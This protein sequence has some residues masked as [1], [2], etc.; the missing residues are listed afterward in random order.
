MIISFFLRNRGCRHRCIFCSE[1]VTGGEGAEDL[2]E[3]LFRETV[4]KHLRT[5][6]GRRD[7]EIAFYGGNFL[8][9]EDSLQR[10]LLRLAAPYVEHGKVRS[11]RV[12]TRPDSITDERL[13]FLSGNHV[14]TIEI[15]ASQEV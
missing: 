13:R 14:E 4:E 15:G 7:G 10:R 9:M 1:R 11:I 3:S 6:G 5:G 12:S 2:T 8:E